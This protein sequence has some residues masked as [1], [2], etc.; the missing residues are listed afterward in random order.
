MKLIKSIKYTLYNHYYLKPIR[1]EGL[2]LDYIY[3]SIILSKFRIK[4]LKNVIS[5]TYKCGHACNLYRESGS[6]IQDSGPNILFS[7]LYFKIIL[8]M[9]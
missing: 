9:V 7:I 6:Q 5:H 3:G 1:N 4:Y 8:L 2:F